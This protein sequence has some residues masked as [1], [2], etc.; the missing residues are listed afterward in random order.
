MPKLILRAAIGICSLLLGWGLGWAD[1]APSDA[2]FVADFDGSVVARSADGEKVPPLQAEG[3][4]SAPGLHGQALRAEGCTLTYPPAVV[5][6][7]R[8]TLVMWFSP[9]AKALGQDKRGAWYFYFQDADEWGPAG[10]PRLWLYER[11]LRFDVECS[12]RY[13]AGAI[14]ERMGWAVGP[15]RQLAA[16]WD[17][18]R[19]MALYFDGHKL[20][21]RTNPS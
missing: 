5:P 14:P 20:A 21:G 10:M 7:E 3:V 11:R 9:L 12:P 18:A 19:Q 6:R 2:V 1:S 13:I 4:K 17:G 15:W 8:G 16:T